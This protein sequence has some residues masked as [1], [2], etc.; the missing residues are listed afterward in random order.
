MANKQ[1]CRDCVWFVVHEDV[2]P[3]EPSEY[4]CKNSDWG[5]YVHP[6][7][8]ACGGIGYSKRGQPQEAQ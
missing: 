4:G 3:D 7:S 8:P 5:G 1:S 6:D 2:R